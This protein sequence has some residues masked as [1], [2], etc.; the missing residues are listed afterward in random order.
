V[1]KS[2]DEFATTRT[3]SRMTIFESESTELAQLTQG[4]ST[5]KSI[6]YP[7]ERDWIGFQFGR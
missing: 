3:S 6:L 4:Y 7:G 1:T 5:G 2:E